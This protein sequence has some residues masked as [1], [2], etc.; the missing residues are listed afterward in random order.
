MIVLAVVAVDRYLA[1]RDLQTGVLRAL[2]DFG[3]E[4]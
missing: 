3:R 4:I 1:H 2:E